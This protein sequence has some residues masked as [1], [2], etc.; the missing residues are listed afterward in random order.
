M[1]AFNKKGHP[2]VKCNESKEVRFWLAKLIATTIICAL[3]YKGVSVFVHEEICSEIS[4]G[5]GNHRL[6]MTLHVVQ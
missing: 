4:G 5:S 2:M 3:M 1:R 6:Y